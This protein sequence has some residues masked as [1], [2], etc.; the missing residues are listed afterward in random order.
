MHPPCDDTV[1]PRTHQQSYGRGYAQGWQDAGAALTQMTRLIR[2][3]CP[4]DEDILAPF[5]ECP[6]WDEDT[7]AVCLGPHAKRCP[8]FLG[9]IGPFV[10]CA[11]AYAER[12]SA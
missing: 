12:G 9:T 7:G 6:I 11:F 10:H 4:E 2:Y 8:H 1:R 5:P 3:W